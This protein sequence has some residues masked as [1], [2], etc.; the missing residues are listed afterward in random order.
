MTF[1]DAFFLGALRVN[2]YPEDYGKFE[3]FREGFIFAKLRGRR[4]SRKENPREMAKSLCP[5]LM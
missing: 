3:N 5:L 4:V 2:Q 1:S